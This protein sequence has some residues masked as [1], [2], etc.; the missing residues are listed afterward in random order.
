MA[1]AEVYIRTLQRQAEVR[2]EEDMSKAEAK[3]TAKVE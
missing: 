1:E 3:G 2:D